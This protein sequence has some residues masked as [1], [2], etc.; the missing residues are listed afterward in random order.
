MSFGSWVACLYF[1]IFPSLFV[2]LVCLWF[3]CASWDQNCVFIVQI[4]HLQV[5]ISKQSTSKK[6]KSRYFHLFNDFEGN[7]HTDRIISTNAVPFKKYTFLL[8]L[9]NHHLHFFRCSSYRSVCVSELKLIDL[10]FEIWI[11]CECFCEVFY[12]FLL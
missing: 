9:L 5:N 8:H 1:P 10:E 6:G 12:L 3:L 11:T 4:M 2:V 7:E